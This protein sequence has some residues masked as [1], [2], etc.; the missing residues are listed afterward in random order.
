MIFIF[1]FLSKDYLESNQWRMKIFGISYNQ[2]KMSY[3]ISVHTL[4]SVET[5]TQ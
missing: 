4:L 1:D 3:P 5:K 2:W